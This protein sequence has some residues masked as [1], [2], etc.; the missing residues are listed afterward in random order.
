MSINNEKNEKIPINV[1]DIMED[2]RKQIKAEKLAS[3]MPPFSSVNIAASGENWEE[4]MDSLRDMNINYNIPYYWNFQTGKIKNFAKRVVRKLIKCVVYPILMKQV[5]YNTYVVR[6]MNT[7]R[8]FIEN[9]RNINNNIL[10]EHIVP[11][12]EENNHI[13]AQFEEQMAHLREENNHIKAQFEEQLAYLR[14]ENNQIKAQFE[15]QMAHLREENNHIKAQYNEGNSNINN[16]INMINEKIYK[17]DRQSDNFSASIAKIILNKKPFAE[18]QEE[19]SLPVYKETG[20][21]ESSIYTAI[22]YFKFQNNFRG[23]RSQIIAR[24]EKYVKYF[25]DKNNPVLDIGCGRGEFLQV[26]KNNNINA[27]GVDLYPEYVI[28]GELN[29]LDIRQGDGINYLAHTDE[30]FSGIFVSHVIE[31]ISFESLQLLCKSAYEKLEDGACLIFETP[32]P[33]SLSIYTNT[34]YVDPTHIRPVHPVTVEYVLKEIGFKDIEILYTEDSKGE[35]LPLI[36]SS[37]IENI[38][39]V[40]AAIQRVSNMLYGSLDYAI[41][42]KK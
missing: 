9:Q 37:A 39:D 28:E 26:M 6:C 42:A 41:I 31:H 32:N 19:K 1:E 5:E 3:E 15:E 8:Y 12:R 13:K 21:G 20:D 11:L 25:K 36:K 14:E 29:D 2:I 23:T 7:V 17:M 10:H 16:R 35:P 34:F 38:E 40:N 18:I 22:D 33:T 24:Q 4:F 30:V 27:Y